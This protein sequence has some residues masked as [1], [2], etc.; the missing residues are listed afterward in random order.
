MADLDLGLGGWSALFLVSAAVVVA[1]GTAL[2]RAGDAIATRTRL[3]GLFVGMLLLASATSLPEIVTDVSAT[4]D[5][6]PDLAIGDLFGSSMA[7]MA[8]LA[9]IDLAT[10]RRVWP[11]VELGHA[12][13]GAV[14]IALT[15]VIVIGIANPTGIQIGWIGLEPI[16]VVMSYVVAAAW[17]G[18]T[19]RAP[20]GP[21]ATPAEE[22][23]AP[24]GWGLS[25]I[26]SLRRD[27]ATF[28]IAALAILGSGPLL[29]MSADGIA[30]ESGIAETFVGATLL[31]VATSLPE[32]V[33][34]LAAVRIGAYDLAVGNLFGSNAFNMTVVLWV[35]L[36]HTEGPVLDAVS[37][38]QLVPG[39]G[40]VLLMAVAIGALL[41]GDATRLRRGEPDAVLLLVVYVGLLVL[42][43]FGAA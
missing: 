19:G 40:A 27:L 30:T 13:I 16:I 20:S 18:R 29:A 25:R 12:R 21:G 41:G 11:G 31:A 2:A 4:L 24:T 37:P 42:A 39:L 28:G 36:A 14:A 26:G 8:I 35:D 15:V 43:W 23:V 34:A 7:N 6:A 1:A 17:L 22:L 32:L 38:Q 5:G 10:H 33:A 9:I 3:G